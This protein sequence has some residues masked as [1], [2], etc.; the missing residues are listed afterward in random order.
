MK[1]RIGFVSN[2]STSSFLIY[3]VVFRRSEA[4]ALLAKLDKADDGKDKE[5]DEDDFDDSLYEK[6]DEKLDEI[7]EDTCLRFYMPYEGEYVYIGTSW[8][9][10]GD[11]ETG[12]QF[13]QRV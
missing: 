12:K 8:G 5:E 7:I 3:G 2:S 4:A 9:Q 10:V 6:L 1:T 13:K 11:D